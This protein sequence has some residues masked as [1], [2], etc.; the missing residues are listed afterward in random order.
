MKPELEKLMSM[1]RAEIEAGLGKVSVVV[2]VMDAT[3]AK[4]LGYANSSDFV[5]GAASLLASVS[6]HHE[7]GKCE[8]C[9]FAVTC[10]NEALSG[11]LE[12]FV[13]AKVSVC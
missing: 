9:D 5:N 11:G 10:A 2:A 13:G 4:P 3:G 6:N 8:D 1:I 12:R 7:H